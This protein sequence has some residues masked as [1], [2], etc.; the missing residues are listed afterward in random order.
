MKSR[1]PITRK[2][3]GVLIDWTV[4]PFQ[5]LF[6]SGV[7]DFAA[8]E[9]AGCIVFEGG[10]MGSPYEYET[11]RNGIYRLVSGGVVD[12]LVI[13]T[14]SIA[15][16]MSLN[17]AKSF[18]EQFHP[19]PLVS[20]SLEIP[21]ATSVLVDNRP[22][23]R[24]LLLHLIEHHGFR[25]I[26]FVKG[27]IGNQDAADRFRVFQEVMDENKLEADPRFVLQGDFTFNS[28]VD[29]AKE[30][31]R[32]G[33]SDIE[34]LVTANDNMAMGAMEEFHRRG[35]QIPSQIAVTGFDNLDCGDYLFPPL[36]TVQ[37]PIYEQ[38]WTAARLL[39]NKLDKKDVPAKV[40][41][42]TRLVV[43]E[44]CKCHFGVSPKTYSA[45]AL[46][47]S[48]GVH[49]PDHQAVLQ[50]LQEMT[51]P[52][53]FHIPDLGR[54]GVIHRLQQAFWKSP[55]PE[56][57]SEFLAAFEQ[58]VFKPFAGEIDHFTVR[59]LLGEMWKRRAKTPQEHDAAAI[60]EDLCFQ[61]LL[62]MGRKVVEK[63]SKTLNELLQESQKL[64]VIRE[65]L[66]NMD[67]NRQMDV[68]T[69]RLPDMGIESCY[70]SLYHPASGGFSPDS[71][72]LLGIRNKKRI[73]TGRKPMEFP[74]KQLVPDDFLTGNRPHIVIVEA[75]KEFGFIVFETGRR[76]NRFFAYLSDVISGAVQEAILFKALNDQ[77]NGLDRN[78]EHIRQAMAGF[79]QTISATVEARDP[80]T[81]GHQRRVSDLARTIAREMGLPPAQ[82]ECVRMAGII[83]DLGKI[84]IPAEI[85]NR[86]GMLD[87]AE[88]SIVKKHP[89][90]GWDILKNI[91]F[92]WP[93]AEIVHQHHERMN[94]QGYPLGLK[95]DDI[96]MEARILAVADVVEAM[97]S[98]RPYREAPG[99]D[100]ALEEINRHKGSLYDP[101][102]VDI[103]TDLFRVKEYK[104]Q[105]TDVLA[106]PVGKQ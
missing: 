4:D 62:E 104:F 9:G 81:E 94:G 8:A 44:S 65:L 59:T 89:Q 24:Q 29:A 48:P 58:T 67:I 86:T 50:R 7:M 78:L 77:K 87:E 66:F 10:G 26:G 98:H 43:R 33:V 92:P 1:H 19:L 17:E 39:L 76:P 56:N 93:L 71:T 73:H 41:V 63:E 30:V 75:M 28:G 13:L 23:M 18:C 37:L 55:D 12:G 79:I 36:T 102:V 101:Q 61:A 31:I 72:C 42:P 95:R 57:P 45:P 20:V 21:G 96:R 91:D 83:H 100:K 15:H 80:Y 105:R 3:I 53:F 69:R 85:L 40:Y 51:E 84:C 2:T 88:W 54:E 46:P 22:G 90:A 103:C 68:L 106:P 5:Q 99:I 60:V 34:V 35:V 70:V 47:A 49:P 27:R 97:S 11:Q 14:A 82:V 25:R 6:L 16:F 32:K 64:D 52:L 74:S 38:G